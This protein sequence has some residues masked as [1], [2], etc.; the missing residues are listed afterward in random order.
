MTDDDKAVISE[1]LDSIQHQFLNVLS[2]SSAGDYPKVVKS[3][4][5]IEKVARV[6]GVVLRAL[7]AAK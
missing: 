2:A 5:V 6:L 4:A 7:G 3:L 1:Q